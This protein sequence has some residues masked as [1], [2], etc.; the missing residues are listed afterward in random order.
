MNKRLE[1]LV[2][3]KASYAEFAEFF[4]SIDKENLLL[5]KIELFKQN[6]KEFLQWEHEVSK[7]LQEKEPL[8]VNIY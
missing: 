5:D 4:M 2:E 1:K 3:T 6:I 7:A 8:E